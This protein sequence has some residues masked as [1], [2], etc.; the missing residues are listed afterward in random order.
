MK[1]HLYINNYPLWRQ[2]YD[3]IYENNSIIILN[4]IIL[5]STVTQIQ[6]GRPH[7]QSNKKSDYKRTAPRISFKLTNYI[8]LYIQNLNE[9][10]FLENNTHFDFNLHFITQKNHLWLDRVARFTA[11]WH[12]V[13][14]C[15]RNQISHLRTHFFA[16]LTHI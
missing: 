11:G 9:T 6:V 1:N 14:R 3:K 7:S 16:L 8:H 4:R 15:K 2:V 12:I 5:W 13:G 10:W